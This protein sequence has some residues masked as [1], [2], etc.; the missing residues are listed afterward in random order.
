M[1][2]PKPHRPT[3]STTLAAPFFAPHSFDNARAAWQQAQA[4]YQASTQ[5]LRQALQ[6]FLAGDLQGPVR[7]CYPFVRLRTRSLRRGDSRLAY[8]FVAEPGLYET[9]LTRP[10][11]FERYFQDALQRIAEE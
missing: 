7:A 11:L 5:Y 4:I 9:T 3:A 1:K 8:G 10:E 2:S 6:Q